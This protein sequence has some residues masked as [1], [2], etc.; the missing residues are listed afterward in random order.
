ML[1][2]NKPKLSNLGT[3]T[4]K[5]SNGNL[6]KT[7]NF[8]LIV[9]SKPH[10]RVEVVNP[11]G[12]Y[13]QGHEYTI[14]CVAEGYPI[15]TINW[16]FKPCDTFIDCN[17]ERTDPIRQRLNHKITNT[18]SSVS[19]IKEIARRSGQITCQACNPSG[20]IYQSADFFVT[21][22][23]DDGFTV[24]GPEN[25]L[26]GEA[27]SLKCSASKYNFSQDSIEWYKDSLHGAKKLVSNHRYRVD[28]T[29]TKFSFSK[30]LTVLNVTLGDKG[31]Y[32]CKVRKSVDG[33]TPIASRRRSYY[34]NNGRNVDND[35]NTRELSWTLNVLP[36]E[37]PVFIAT[38]LVPIV[39]EDTQPLIVQNPEDGVELFC[40]VH[41]RPQPLITWYF[42]TEKLLPTINTTRVQILEDNQVVR[43][44]YV[45]SKDEGL[46]ECKAENRVGYTQATHLIQLKSTADRE[47]MYAQMSIPV[48][49]AVV[50]ALLVVVLLLIIAK[51]CYMKR[52]KKT[53]SV[54]TA[55]A[56]K[57]PSTPPTPRLT[58]Y[59]DYTLSHQ[60]QNLSDEDQ[61]CR[62]TLTG[63]VSP[64]GTL[65]TSHPTPHP[66]CN[67][68]IYG[69]C[70]YSAAPT[71]VPGIPLPGMHA[72]DPLLQFQKMSICDCSA[73]TLPQGT[74]ERQFPHLYPGNCHAT[75]HRSYYG[76]SNGVGSHRS[77]S[78]S[79]SRRSAEY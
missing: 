10:V 62:V 20:C 58:N 44:N 18:H 19:V 23:P 51:I 31:R 13:S 34:R 75:M 7:E 11:Q 49:I 17:R 50:I 42:N 24:S 64:M 45:S 14:K 56:W 46:Y 55:P 29:T 30:E 12:L 66:C 67:S 6:T 9:R 43:I 39:N 8:T 59:N 71:P 41:G 4:L 36:L 57:E 38:N 26:V 16:Y 40:K 52:Q 28:L 53:S 21:D 2:V 79:P 33:R 35:E 32:Y 25:V 63:S 48:I 78:H 37:P 76:G 65:R 3:Y 22:I 60:T 54:S 61:E 68:E 1:R 73:Q 47:A 69:H 15:P 72:H 70:H 27:I 77:R 5:V 74:L